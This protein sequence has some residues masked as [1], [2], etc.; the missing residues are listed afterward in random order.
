MRDLTRLIAASAGHGPNIGTYAERLLDDPLPWIRMRAVYRLQ[1]L[2]RRHGPG[3]VDT[4]CGRSLDLDVVSVSKIAAMLA[5]ATQHTQPVLPAMPNPAGSPGHHT[6]AGRFARHPGEYARSKT[7]STSVHLTLI[8]GREP[9]EGD[10][11]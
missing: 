8:P 10:R 4:A 9:T 2:V 7:T 11:P 3:P 6:R 1:G 5:K